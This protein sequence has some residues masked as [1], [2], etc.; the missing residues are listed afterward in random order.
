MSNWCDLKSGSFKCVL[1]VGLGAVD[2]EEVIVS[3]QNTI[4]VF[5]FGLLRDGATV[6]AGPVKQSGQE[7]S[8]NERER[9]GL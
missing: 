4:S 3:P 6:H 7:R 2:S 5:H 9:T 1:T 8:A